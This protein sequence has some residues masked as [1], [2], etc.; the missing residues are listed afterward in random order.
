MPDWPDDRYPG[1]FLGK[2]QYTIDATMV[3]R[4]VAATGDDNP[5]YRERSPWG[6]PVAPALLFH[7]EQYAFPVD[8]WYL[9]EL[10]GTLHVKQQWELFR[11]IPLGA[12]VTTTLQ[13]VDRY[14]RRDRDV[15]VVECGV[16]EEQGALAARSRCHQSFL[17]DQQPDRDVAAPGRERQHAGPEEAERR[18]L[19][20]LEPVT[21]R[22]DLERCVAFSGPK[23]NLH[24]NIEAARSYGFP[25]I[26]VQ[27]TMSTAFISQMMTRRFGAGWYEGG[28]LDLNF[29]NVLWCDETVTAAGAVTEEMVEGS[30]RRSV[31]DVWT[32][33]GPGTKTTAGRASAL[34]WDKGASG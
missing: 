21:Q 17:R 3:D 33:K 14:V 28:R 32:E 18:E 11:A 15:V 4:Y 24:T 8:T 29:V 6:G 10:V 7:S 30:R 2:H 13:V 20:R 25:A 1:K 19:E 31:C 22:V 9:P 5:W 34:T 26:V 16:F 12:T 27:G 23:V